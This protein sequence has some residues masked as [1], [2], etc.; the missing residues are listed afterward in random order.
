MTET[1]AEYRHAVRTRHRADTIARIR[2]KLTDAR[3]EHLSD[4]LLILIERALDRD[5]PGVIEMARCHT[6]FFS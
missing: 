2:D 6:L 4:P 3:L 1:L 5:V